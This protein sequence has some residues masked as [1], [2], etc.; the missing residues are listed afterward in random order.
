MNWFRQVFQ[1][2]DGESIR[3]AVVNS[4]ELPEIRATFDNLARL[5]EALDGE[6]VDGLVELNPA[7]IPVLKRVIVSVRR[8]EAGRIEYDRERARHPDVLRAFET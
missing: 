8:N 4:H 5:D 1:D 2:G 7:L 6:A 3:M